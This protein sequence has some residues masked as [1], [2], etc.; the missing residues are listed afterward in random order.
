MMKAIAVVLIGL[1]ASLPLAAGADTAAARAPSSLATVLQKIPAS[2]IAVPEPS[3]A[4]LFGLGFLGLV[5]LRRTRSSPL[6]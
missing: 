2:I 1:A 3:S 6:D 5:V 4:W